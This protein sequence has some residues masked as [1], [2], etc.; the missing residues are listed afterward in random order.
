MKLDKYKLG[1]IIEEFISG[2]W[3]N[4]E[5]KL[6]YSSDFIRIYQRFSVSLQFN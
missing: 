3:G 5:F 6:R 1:E 2:D 4:V